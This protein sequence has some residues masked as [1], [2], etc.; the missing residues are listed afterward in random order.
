MLFAERLLESKTADKYTFI[1]YN[2]IIS[3]VCA[4][5]YKAYTVWKHQLDL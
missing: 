3:D 1:L 4:Y 5:M 2:T